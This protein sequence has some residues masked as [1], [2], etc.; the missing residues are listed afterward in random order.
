MQEACLAKP[1]KLIAWSPTL[2]S[3]AAGIYLN[4][5]CCTCFVSVAEPGEVWVV[6]SSVEHKNCLKNVNNALFR[7]SG[8]LSWKHALGKE[9]ASELQATDSKESKQ[10]EC[11]PPLVGS[12]WEGQSRQSRSEPDA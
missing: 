6:R 8:R 1:W 5:Y 10:S 12:K 7:Q 11:L 2:R 3:E 4:L 9:I